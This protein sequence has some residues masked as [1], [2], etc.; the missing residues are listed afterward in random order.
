MDNASHLGGFIVGLWAALCVIPPEPDN[1]SWRRMDFIRLAGLIGVLVTGLVIVTT[2]D[3]KN[4]IA[5]GEYN[6]QKGLR[7]L[8]HDDVQGAIGYFDKALQ[9]EPDNSAVYLDRAM[10]WG[11]LDKWDRSL[12][13]ADSAL[14]LD[15]K[16]KKGYF[17]L[18]Y[19]HHHLGRELDAVSD[20]NRVIFIDP[21]AAVAYNNRAWSLETL[22]KVDA[23]ITD[24][25]TAIGLD[26]RAP[27]AYDTRGVAYCLKGVYDQAIIDFDKYASL[28]PDEGA[29]YYHRAFAYLKLGKALLARDD[30]KRAR[31]SK[32]ELEPWEKEW[33]KPV[34]S[35]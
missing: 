22:G 10:A 7:L 25:N 20:L 11:R 12:A 29:V 3:G 17:V 32:Y 6:Y 35:L 4:P 9:N 5:I 16:S 21:R 34:L 15:P 26:A 28:Q 33:L 27:S 2:I 13:D 1:K 24:C 23:A 30:M 31:A 8:R 18:S 19:A 14:K